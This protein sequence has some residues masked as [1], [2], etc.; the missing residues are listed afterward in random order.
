VEVI[1]GAQTGD[2]YERQATLEQVFASNGGYFAVSDADAYMSLEWGDVGRS[3]WTRDTHI[4]QGNG[5]LPKGVTGVRFRSYLLGVPATV[6]AALADPA[7]PPIIISAGGQASAVT[8]G[9]TVYNAKAYGAKGNGTADDTAAIQTAASAARTNGGGILFFPPG[10]YLVSGSIIIGTGVEVWGSGKG[11]T[12]VKRPATSSTVTGVFANFDQTFGGADADIAFRFITVWR[13]GEA[14][15]ANTPFDNAIYMKGVTRFVLQSCRVIGA[16]KGIHLHGCTEPSLQDF[17]VGNFVDNGVAINW[18][19]APSSSYARVSGGTF[20]TPSVSGF[21]LG[22]SSLLFTAGVL[23]ADDLIFRDCATNAIEG[24]SGAAYCELTNVVAIWSGALN[25]H[26]N[27]LIT[28]TDEIYLSDMRLQHGSVLVT[29]MT[30]ATDPRNTEVRFSNVNVSGGTVAIANTNRFSVSGGSS[31]GAANNGLAIQGCADGL[32]DGMEVSYAGHSGV[33]VSTGGSGPNGRIRFRSVD[34]FGNGTAGNPGDTYGWFIDAG[35]VIDLDTC[36]GYDP[37]GAAG[38]QTHAVYINATTRYRFAA[39][40]FKGN[41]TGELAGFTGN[42]TQYG[43]ISG[44]LIAEALQTGSLGVTAVT[45]ATA[46][47]Y[48]GPTATITLD[49]Q[50]EIEITFTIPRI[51]TLAQN[52]AICIFDSFN[53][54]AAATLGRA[55]DGG[56]GTA[57]VAVLNGA[58][59]NVTVTPAAGTHQY[60]LRIFVAAGGGT[61]TARAGNGGAGL[62]MPATLKVRKT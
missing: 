12:F 2:E 10:T 11:A 45:E 7:E 57:G 16:A 34:S 25:V 6:T 15:V 5:V 40:N 46:D 56:S 20:D 13:E 26:N 38:T 3:E 21:S 33:Y 28:N 48:I 17:W 54:G 35:D 44:Q 1:D 27:I 43:W 60:S 55:M 36:A 32:V 53:G 19:D 49:G 30:P 23:I 4:P 50:T 9:L 22:S 51:D 52:Y 62:F 61:I 39:C 29:T 59:G 58:A 37:L 47:L 18:A 14:T 41:K 8:G 31:T 42:P 24:G